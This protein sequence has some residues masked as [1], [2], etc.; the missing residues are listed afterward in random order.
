MTC[1]RERL[2]RFIRSFPD[3]KNRNLRQFT[4]EAIE[5]AVHEII[6]WRRLTNKFNAKN[7]AIQ[8]GRAAA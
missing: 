5:E 8:E 6:F 3:T 2:E 4:D 7:R 1:P